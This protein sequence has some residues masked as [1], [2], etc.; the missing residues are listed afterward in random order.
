M[1][2]LK[3]LHTAITLPMNYNYLSSPIHLRRLTMT[4]FTNIANADFKLLLNKMLSL[5]SL[6]ITANGKQ[7]FT[8]GF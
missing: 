6:K 8:G 4:I 7:W 2:H 5:E 1:P 3:S